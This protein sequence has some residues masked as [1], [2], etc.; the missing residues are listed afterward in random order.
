MYE[1]V[2]YIL[3][4][5]TPNIPTFSCLSRDAPR[6][7]VGVF[8]PSGASIPCSCSAEQRGLLELQGWEVQML[9]RRCTM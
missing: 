4:V 3:H 9:H 8:R 7:R 6:P 2:V 1:D 5:F